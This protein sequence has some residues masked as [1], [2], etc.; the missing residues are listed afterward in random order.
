[1][2]GIKR[3]IPFRMALGDLNGSAGGYLAAISEDEA[4]PD[5]AVMDALLA[6]E[7]YL[8]RKIAESYYNGNRTNEAGLTEIIKQVSVSSGELLP[9]HIGPVIGVKVDGFPA[10]HC[11]VSA[12]ARLAGKNPLNLTLQNGLYGLEDNR[13]YLTAQT[14]DSISGLP[15]GEVYLF[16]WQIPSFVDLASFK[17]SDSPVPHEY[18]RCWVDL[19][20]AAILPREGAMMGAAANYQNRAN[21]VLNEIAGEHKLRPVSRD[22]QSVGQ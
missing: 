17:A 1:M 12:V 5:E 16:Q 21:M 7:A 19:T 13:I 18:L 2:A 15:V 10:E 22:A 8:L 14:V 9:R 11:A 20:M 3:N 6:Q 4:Y